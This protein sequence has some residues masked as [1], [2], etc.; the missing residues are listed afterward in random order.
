MSV[1]IKDKDTV[2]IHIPKTAG[3]SIIDAMRK[4]GDVR[5]IP[6]HRSRGNWHSPWV[7]CLKH[8]PNYANSFKFSVV[9][10]PWDR[11]ASW[12]FFRQPFLKKDSKEYLLMQEDFNKWLDKYINQPWED[13][14]FSL[15]YSQSFWLGDAEYDIIIRFENLIEDL[16]KVDNLLSVASLGHKNKSS[17]NNNYR[18]IYNQQ[19]INLVKKVYEED[20]ERF[21]Y[22]F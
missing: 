17:N 6:T 7:D 3:G 15:K 21:K 5:R 9:R 19:S 16:S 11:V 13:T 1:Y 8:N 20:I 18:E 12:F 10:N 22:S 4:V 2:F 14:W